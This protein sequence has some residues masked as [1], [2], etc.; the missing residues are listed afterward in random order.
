MEVARRF[1]RL[2]HGQ[3]ARR[4]L[5]SAADSDAKGSYRTP[6]II[7]AKR[8]AERNDFLIVSAQA[9]SFIRFVIGESHLTLSEVS[10]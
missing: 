1:F 9:A 3:V 8:G 4:F 7:L 5:L 2:Q 10:E 6:D